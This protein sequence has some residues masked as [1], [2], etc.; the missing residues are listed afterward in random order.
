MSLVR[1]GWRGGLPTGNPGA[2][3]HR[4]RHFVVVNVLQVCF[5]FRMFFLFDNDN[6]KKSVTA[7]NLRL[8]YSR[9]RWFGKKKFKLAYEI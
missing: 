8:W 5:F 2:Q 7:G 6:R 4:T 3:P 1:I 9:G